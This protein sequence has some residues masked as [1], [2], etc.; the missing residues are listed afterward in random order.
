MENDQCISVKVLYF[1][2]IRL[3]ATRIVHE[4]IH[5]SVIQYKKQLRK[6]TS[7]FTYT[8]DLLELYLGE[9]TIQETVL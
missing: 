3:N 1:S 4:T 9:R 6:K 8:S 5:C 7:K 2:E